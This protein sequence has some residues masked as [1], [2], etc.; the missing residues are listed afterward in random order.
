MKRALVLILMLAMAVATPI[1]PDCIYQPIESII[2]MYDQVFLGETIEVNPAKEN[3]SRLI[4]FSYVMKLKVLKAWKG[5]NTPTIILTSSMGYFSGD[6]YLVFAKCNIIEY[7]SPSK[8]AYEAE[9]ELRFLGKP[10]YVP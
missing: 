7:C 5:V 1:R 10:T 4:T 8:K 3:D 6:T 9:R 2:E